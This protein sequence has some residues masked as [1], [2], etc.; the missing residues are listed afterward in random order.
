MTKKIS[1]S[2]ISKWSDLICWHIPKLQ[3][4]SSYRH[5]PEAWLRIAMYFELTCNCEITN[6]LFV[7]LLFNAALHFVGQL[8]ICVFI[9]RVLRKSAA[10]SLCKPIFNILEGERQTAPGEE[11]KGRGLT[12][13]LGGWGGDRE[14]IIISAKRRLQIT[15]SVCTA[16]ILL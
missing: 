14:G 16:V 9:R 2:M 10:L 4:A 7:Y 1:V 11:W 5:A 8:Y 3:A 12:I 13:L 6:N 15:L